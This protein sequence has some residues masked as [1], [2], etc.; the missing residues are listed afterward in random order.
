MSIHTAGKR[1]SQKSETIE[2]VID[3]LRGY[4]M[5]IS[6]GLM[7]ILNTGIEGKFIMLSKIYSETFQKLRGL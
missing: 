3:F 7:G 6:I 2:Q 1:K 4:S 5:E